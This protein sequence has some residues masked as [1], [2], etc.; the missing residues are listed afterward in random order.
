MKKVFFLI[1]SIVILG[2]VF[3]GCGDIAKITAPGTSQEGI[4]SLT[5]A[6]VTPTLVD[7]WTSGDAAFECGQVTCCD[8]K[9]HYKVD[10]WDEIDPNG[11]HEHAGNTITITAYEDEEGEYKT[12]DWVSEYPV[13]CVIV[14]AGTGAYVYCYDVAYSDT[15]LLT[16]EDKGISHVTFCWDEG[17]EIE[18]TVDVV[19]TAVTSYTRTHLWDIDK[20][21]ET[22]NEFTESDL[23][24]IW[25]Y[26]DGREDEA[27]TWTVEVTYLGYEDSNWQ[28]SGNITILNNT[29]NNI[30]INYEDIVDEL[31]IDGETEGMPITIDCSPAGFPVTLE[32]GEYLTCSY[33]EDLEG[34]L[35]GYN[36]VTVTVGEDDYGDIAYL[37]WGD[38]TTEVNDCITVEDTNPEFA[39]QYGDVELCAADYDVDEVETFTYSK[40]FTWEDYGQESCGDYIYDN[41]ASIVEIGQSADARLLVNVQCY[42]YETAYAKGD[43]ATCF[44]PTFS[45]WGWT[46]P[47]EPGWTYEMELWA[48]AGQCDT[49][50]GTL[51]GSVTVDGC[52]VTYYLDSPFILEE[53]HV[54]I[55]CTQFPQVL[56]GK[57]LVDTVAPGSYYID[58]ECEGDKYVIAHAVV[59]IPDPEFGP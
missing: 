16:P 47:I 29:A 28:V 46:N 4:T 27:A 34:P 26:I 54:Y 44:I 48:A 31:W 52:E 23:P 8:A 3:A 10:N 14:K 41:T 53:T 39:A 59:G 21:V 56:R 19:K 24:K 17:P 36:E 37:Q 6:S 13:S 45:Q 30:V 5:K 57:K 40:E 9:Y 11:E 22:E 49:W 38:P 20:K 18:E 50:R 58:C 15:G 12:F 43:G 42:I 55:G 25:L 35:E 33:T 2:L 1:V 32:P 7:P 51:V